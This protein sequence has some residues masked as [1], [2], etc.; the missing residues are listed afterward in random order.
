MLQLLDPRE[1]TYRGFQLTCAVGIPVVEVSDE[2]ASH[3]GII[4]GLLQDE[5]RGRDCTIVV[6]SRPCEQVH[7]ENAIVVP[8]DSRNDNFCPRPKILLDNPSLDL[9]LLA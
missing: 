4:D 8:L 1:R 9:R 3:I 6:S 5:Q 7:I 2:H